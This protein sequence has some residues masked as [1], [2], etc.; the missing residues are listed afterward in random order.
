MENKEKR[1]VT[2]T[3]RGHAPVTIDLDGTAITI[4]KARERI[5]HSGIHTTR[6]C[7]STGRLV[8]APKE[9]WPSLKCMMILVASIDYYLA[10]RRHD[11]RWHGS[12]GG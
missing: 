2:M 3:A 1:T 11:K 8:A 5:G 7:V 6:T 10:T 4:E 9:T 12:A